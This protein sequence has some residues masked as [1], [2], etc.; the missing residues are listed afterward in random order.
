MHCTHCGNQVEA[1]V[2]FCSHCGK[3][4]PESHTLTSRPQAPNP[5][6]FNIATWHKFMFSVLCIW[7]ISLILMFGDW[8]ELKSF[9]YKTLYS[10]NLFSL[11][12]LFTYMKRNGISDSK[13]DI[14]TPMA[15]QFMIIAFFFIMLALSAY[16]LYKKSKA[17]F[18]LSISISVFLVFITW[19]LTMFILLEG[20]CDDYSNK[21]TAVPYFFIALNV[22]STVLLS[23]AAK[24]KKN[25]C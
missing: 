2:N 14:G 12:E 13:S 7:G 20:D 9:S 4:I 1:G 11:G 3:S 25:K 23:I 15:F 17:L 24:K 8:F 6:S 22:L 16:F 18:P 19:L 5:P 10:S 21:L